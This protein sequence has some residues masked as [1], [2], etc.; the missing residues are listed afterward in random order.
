MLVCCRFTCVESRRKR[1]T[2]DPTTMRE[3]G[4][5]K[6][7]RYMLES[8]LVFACMGEAADWAA[9]LQLVRDA[10]RCRVDGHLYARH[11]LT[12]SHRP[13]PAAVATIAVANLTACDDD[14]LLQRGIQ[15][16]AP[17]HLLISHGG[18]LRLVL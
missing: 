2:M 3:S 15:A 4:E 8:N 18:S 16:S 11:G 7:R 6:E 17:E 1:Q 5:Y 10:A 13:Y 12:G 14:A 9:A